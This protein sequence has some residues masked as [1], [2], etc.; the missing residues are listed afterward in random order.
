[1]DWVV[2]LSRGSFILGLAIADDQP[3]EANL[4]GSMVVRVF[5]K[6]FNGLPKPIRLPARWPVK[7]SELTF[8]SL[9]LRFTTDSLNTPIP[10]PVPNTGIGTV[11]MWAA[12]AL[13]MWALFAAVVAAP[14]IPTMM[15]AAILL[16]ALVFVFLSRRIVFDGTAV[17]LLFFIIV[18]IV[19]SVLSLVPGYS[20][21][22]ALLVS[23]FMMSSLMVVACCRSKVSVN[24][25]FFGFVAASA[26]VGFIGLY[27]VMSGHSP[28][29]GLT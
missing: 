26:V 7:L 9:A 2:K 21:P 14:F 24:T 15:L 28:G 6:I 23:L 11:A 19:A 4:K 1:M 3:Q 29:H 13:P 27:H 16:P 20:I 8:G 5:D 10:P 18:N 22:I 12:F 17:F 25:F